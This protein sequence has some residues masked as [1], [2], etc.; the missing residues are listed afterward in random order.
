MLRHRIKIF[1][2]SLALFDTECE[3]FGISVEHTL[4]MNTVLASGTVI[5]V[6]VYT[7]KVMRAFMNTSAP[8]SKSSLI[9]NQLSFMTFVLFLVQA[10]LALSL[11]LC[12]VS[13]PLRPLYFVRFIILFSYVIPVRLRINVDMARILLNRWIEGDLEIATPRYVRLIYARNL[14]ELATC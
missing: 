5:G 2:I 4:W 11:A 14:I 12:R 7:G 1:T 3:T 9:E 13:S 8:K 10:A 6:V